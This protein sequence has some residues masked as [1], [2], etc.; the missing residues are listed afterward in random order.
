[1]PGPVA[2]KPSPSHE[3]LDRLIAHGAAAFPA[4][5][6]HP[7]VRAFVAERAPAALRARAPI[8]RAADLYVA[9][10]CAA[11]DPAAI[12]H[13]DASLAAVVRPTLAR[14]G[15]PADDDDEIVQRVR[16]A[17]LVARESGTRGIASYS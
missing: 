15:L 6:Q 13:V 1:M 17:L 5:A 7:E 2:F 8:S 4:I 14:L 3:A 10:A 9:A 11:G 16:V 12:A